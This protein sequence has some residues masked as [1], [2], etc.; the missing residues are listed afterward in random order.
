MV[1]VVNR[2]GHPRRGGANGMSLA[3]SELLDVPIVG[4]GADLFA[5]DD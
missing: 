5:C 4:A 2:A 3:L 1:T